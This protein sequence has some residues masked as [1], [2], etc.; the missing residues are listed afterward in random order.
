M[1]QLS[2]KEKAIVTD[3]PG[4]TRDLLESEIIL[5]GI[6]LTFIDTAGIR[7]T[8]N[9]IEKIGISRTQ[10]ALRNADVITLIYEL[11]SY[12]RYLQL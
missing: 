1:N 9:I 12:C 10:K 8:E 7:E 4:T 5:E 11:R 6:P 2:K 3:L